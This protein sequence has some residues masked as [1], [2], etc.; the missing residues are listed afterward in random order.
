MKENKISIVI[1][2]PVQEV[3]DFTTNPKSTH[4]WIET[5]QEEISDAYPPEVGTIYKNTSNGLDWDFYEVIELEKNKI[6]TL[7]DLED[8]YH[9]RYSYKSLDENTTELEYFEWMAQG[10]L[11]NPFKQNVLEKLKLVM[12]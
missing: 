11:S 6:F 4:L 12:E 2:K 1:Y 5:M 3:F 8:N 7:S 9:V 10:D